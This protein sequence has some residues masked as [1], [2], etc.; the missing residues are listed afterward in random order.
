MRAVTIRVVDDLINVDEPAWP[1]VQ[2]WIADAINRVEV[3]PRPS[4]EERRQAL[5]A[6]QVTTR[7]PMGA[8]IYE[9]GGLL[10][11]GGWLRVYGGGCERLKS[12]S[13]W[14]TERVGYEVSAH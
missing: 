14:N 3:L 4:E 8:I 6:T 9:C 11:D 13:W 12:L 5:L 1:I 7:S 10:V 2:S